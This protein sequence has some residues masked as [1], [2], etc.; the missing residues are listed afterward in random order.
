[1]EAVSRPPRPKSA[2]AR[3]MRSDTKGSALN[4][5]QFQDIGS[6]TDLDSLEYTGSLTSV[7]S[8]R[9]KSANPKLQR[10]RFPT[11]FSM[12]I[13]TFPSVLE[14]PTSTTIAEMRFRK[15]QTMGGTGRMRYS[16]KSIPETPLS[17]ETVRE[18]YKTA[19]VLK[20]LGSH[21]RKK[22]TRAQSSKD[23]I[24][25]VLKK[26]VAEKLN[27]MTGKLKTAVK[28]HNAIKSPF[29]NDDERVEHEG[30]DGGGGGGRG[31][32]PKSASNVQRRGENKKAR[33]KSAPLGGGSGGSRKFVVNKAAA[34]VDRKLVIRRAK[35]EQRKEELKR[36]GSI[37]RPASAAPAMQRQGALSVSTKVGTMRPKARPRSAAMARKAKDTSVSKREKALLVQQLLGSVAGNTL[38]SPLMTKDMR[39]EIFKMSSEK[40]MNKA[41]KF[42]KKRVEME[43]KRIDDIYQKDWNMRMLR[44]KAM[45]RSQQDR[46][47]RG[48]QLLAAMHLANSMRYFRLGLYKMYA[49]KDLKE[50]EQK[51]SEVITRQLRLYSYRCYRSKV[52]GAIKVLGAFFILRIRVWKKRRDVRCADMVTDF[53]RK[54]KKEKC[55]KLIVKGGKLKRWNKD[56]IVVQN[57]WRRKARSI[58]AQVKFINLQLARHQEKKFDEIVDVKYEEAVELLVPANEEIERKNTS[59]KLMKKGK[60][61]PRVFPKPKTEMRAEFLKEEDLLGKHFVPEEIRMGIIRYYLMQAKRLHGEKLAEWKAN[62]DSFMKTQDEK[63]L[64]ENGL[65]PALIEPVKPVF[66]AMMSDLGVIFLMDTCKQYMTVLRRHWDPNNPLQQLPEFKELGF[67]VAERLAQSEKDKKFIDE[68]GW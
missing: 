67:S 64:E 11:D 17:P 29:N 53:L 45:N 9:P 6:L 66:K 27:V 2:H 48:R 25:E 54:L 49:Q 37:K 12:S 50:K 10:S 34:E 59:R 15:T 41:K 4:M 33:P 38:A 36:G 62:H 24:A 55:L 19:K 20:A 63:E 44:L 43:K 65:P 1:M 3:A 35:E 21:D 56:I 13:D 32:R 16:R 22:L 30:G 8:A 18:N 46:E 61:L 42:K 51:S 28:L 26:E 23:T 52:R 57:G 58:S 60:M 7:T 40:R 39:V 5:L 31:K 68:M 14:I 47:N